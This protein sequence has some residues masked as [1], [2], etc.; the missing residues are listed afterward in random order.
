MAILEQRL[1]LNEF[2]ALPEEKPALEYEDGA[3]IQKVP[4]MGRHS[5]LQWSACEQ[6]NRFVLPSKVAMAF[7]ELRTTF[8]G[9]SR[10]PGV[11]VY[12]WGRTPRTDTGEVVDLFTD[13]PDIVAEIVSPGQRVNALVTRCVWFVS[14]GVRVALL[15]D[16]DDRSIIVF[17]PDTV[18]AARRGD[19]AVD[20]EVAPHQTG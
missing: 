3:V 18:P 4:S 11:S 19:D 13:P 5:T 1:T 17:R 15:V 20:L 2:L 9:R 14:N 12:L 7:P 10:V 16:P 6:L 8:G